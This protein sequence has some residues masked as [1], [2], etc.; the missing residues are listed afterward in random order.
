MINIGKFQNCVCRGRANPN[1][2]CDGPLSFEEK[3]KKVTLEPKAGEE[4]IA[5]VID[6]CVCVDK[7]AKCDGMFLY[8][9]INKRW[10]IL[11]ELKG[12]DLEH[13]F[14]QLAFMKSHRTEYKE[15]YNLFSEENRYSLCEKAFIVSNHILQRTEHQKLEKENGIR[16]TKILHSAATK[17]I[18]NL[19]DYL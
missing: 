13:A 1:D 4:A 18:P 10:I 12:G 9:R 8:K 6:G 7:V 3:G 15:F 11:V 17:P 2:L 5:V 19:R 14:E 16:V